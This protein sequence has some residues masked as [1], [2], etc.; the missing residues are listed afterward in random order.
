MFY[1][2]ALDSGCP[3][4][5]FLEIMFVVKLL[6]AFRKRPPYSMFL[7]IMFAMKDFVIYN[8]IVEDYR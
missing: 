2:N 5:I 1:A 8:Q 6:A 3:R 4:S 7:R